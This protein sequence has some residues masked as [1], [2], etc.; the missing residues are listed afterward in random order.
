MDS[1]HFLNLEYLL[2][3]VYDIANAILTPLGYPLDGGAS[4]GAPGATG[5]AQAAGHTGGIF[6]YLGSFLTSTTGVIAL[7]G[8]IAGVA[9]LCLAIWV[10]VRLLVVEHEGY[11]GHEEHE[12]AQIE[13]H[14]AAATPKNAQWDRVFVLAASG[15]ES[16]WRRA[17]LEADIMLG[18]LLKSLGY[19]GDSVG[20]RLRD[21]N[22]LQFTTLDLA[23]KAHK[24]RNDIAHGGE[25]YHLSQR[26]ANA[27]IDLYRRVFEEFNYI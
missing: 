6:S 11:H 12:H 21:A 23:W 16:D 10:R 5:G 3:R 8:M 1:V 27:T 17:I 15:N 25:G 19:R 7:L 4:S 24:V 26:E 20:E 9:L 13:A 2:L 22:P 18:D 14:A